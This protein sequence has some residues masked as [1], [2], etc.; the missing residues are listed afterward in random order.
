MPYFRNQKRHMLAGMVARIEQSV[1]ATVGQL[2]VTAWVT[3]EPVPYAERESGTKME[4]KPGDKWG[5][6]FDCA[7]FHFKGTVPADAAGEKIVLLVDVNGEACVVD[8]KGVPVIG[9]TCL[10][11]GFDFS[12]GGPGKR[13]VPMFEQAAGGEEIDVWADAGCNDLFGVLIADGTLKEAR[14][15]VCHQEM[16]ALLYD[17]EVL[18]ELMTQLPEDTPRWN[19][20][21]AALDE[22]A[23]KMVN[24][25]EEEAREARGALANELAKE[26]GDPS[27][28][29]SAIGHS[30]IDLGWLW[31]IRETYRKGARTFATVMRLM[32]RYP[33]YK[34]GASQPQLFQWMKDMYPELYAQMRARIEEG[35]FEV[36]GAMWV[37]ADANV[38]GGESLVRQVLYGKRFFRDEFGVDIKILWLPDVFGY[39]GALPQILKKAGVDFFMTQKMSW[40]KINKFP[41]HTFW[42]QGIDGSRVLAHMLPEE[43]YNSPASPRAIAYTTRNFVDKSVSDRCLLLYGI[44][45]G[46]GGPGEEHVERLA[47]EKNLD[48]LVPVVQ[49]TGAQFFER[50]KDGEGYQTWVGELYLEMHQ[51]TYTTQGRNKRYNRKME[52]ALREAEMASIVALWM[53]G[54]EYPQAELEAIW[55]E[56]LLYQFHDILPGSSI[57][58]VYTES[59]ARYAVMLAQTEDI[60]AKAKAPVMRS[61]NT[62]GMAKPAIVCN[63]LSWERSEYV[64]AAGGWVRV[65]APSMGYV[66]VDMAQTATVASPAATTEQIEN[67]LLRVSFNPDGSISSVY[68]KE[69]DRE[70]IAQG[71]AA[72][73]LAVYRDEQGSDAWD[74]AMAYA[75]HEPEQFALVSAEPFADG[76]R[77]GVRMVYRYGEGETASEVTQEVALTTGSRRVDFVTRVDWRASNRMLRTLFPLAV[78]A[79]EATCEVQFGHVRRPTHRNTSWDLA[80]FEICAHKWIDLSD[81][82]YG[83]ALLNDC[84]YG[85]RAVG[86]LL[87]INLLRSPG[88]PDPVADRAVHEI[89]YCLLPHAGDHLCGG[90]IRAGY[91][92][93]V[94]LQ[95]TEVE[96]SAGDMPA[97]ASMIQVDAANVIVEA[98][99][100]AEDSDD[101][102][103]R[104]YEAHGASGKA[105]VSFGFPV[106]EVAIVDL[107]EENA[108][109]VEAKEGKVELAFGPFELLTLRIAKA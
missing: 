18:H 39:S 106:G 36:Q 51:G 38:T 89:T 20:L 49:E 98:V 74:F 96:A 66:A 2:E 92:L 100:K 11:S 104:L 6:L 47:R 54:V 41:H 81:R 79:S 75:E 8:D 45:D 14:I 24:F 101:M 69:N 84:K 65:T 22:A 95:V 34:F 56:V 13:V 108:T 31:P 72:N 16:R 90:V 73:V 83:V 99:K 57:T 43:T 10:G 62:A 3:P 82:G 70:A 86:N 64:K 42:W 55:K 32:E 26:G 63:S 78:T 50:I 61:M 52:I 59:L 107:M 87:D 9:L 103:V 48:G 105:T 58:R 15:A 25:T 102:I 94:P 85:H 60:V 44:G 5:G 1:Y 91:E 46:G 27:L 76:P 88:F 4:L 37:E 77:A 68:D 97:Q 33:D 21:W 35:R 17:Y 7:W 30:H 53:G 28:T 23:G 19:S 12:L 109:V 40:N 93:N 29:I 80:K 67:D 71:E